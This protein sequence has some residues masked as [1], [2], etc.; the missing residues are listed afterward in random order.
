VHRLKKVC[1]SLHLHVVERLKDEVLGDFVCIALRKPNDEYKQMLIT[2]AS[3]YGI[4]SDYIDVIHN[5]YTEGK[6]YLHFY[7]D[8]KKPYA[9]D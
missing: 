2:L 8:K 6:E 5:E 1:V 9:E 7:L 4:G 3:R